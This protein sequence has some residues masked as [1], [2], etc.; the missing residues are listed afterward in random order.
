MDPMQ[1]FWSLQ[2]VI[3]QRLLEASRKRLIGRIEHERKSRY[4]ARAPAGDNES[5]GF[6]IFRYIDVD[7]SE[8]VIRTIH[9][10][11]TEIPLDLVLHTP[12][13][14]ALAATQIGR[15]VLKRKGKVTVFVPH[16]GRTITQLPTSGHSPL[17]CA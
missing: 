13:G 8:E 16:Y 7:D 3:T 6:P 2:P 17:D 9:L 5:L 14:L 15:A 12:G 11:D 1:I 10:T 4:F